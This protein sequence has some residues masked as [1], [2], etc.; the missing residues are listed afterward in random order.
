MEFNVNVNE[1]VPAIKVVE[2]NKVRDTIDGPAFSTKG[3]GK[4]I[5]VTEESQD[6]LSGESIDLAHPTDT[7][8]RRRGSYVRPPCSVRKAN[9]RI[10][11]AEKAVIQAALN[12][13]FL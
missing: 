10:R 3:T 12:A 11:K 2:N 5:E 4:A 13:P 1:A 8:V 6:K 7:P 9:K